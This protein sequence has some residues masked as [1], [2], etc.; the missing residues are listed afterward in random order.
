MTYIVTYHR[1]T[2]VN[3]EKRRNYCSLA[4]VSS[5]IQ[6]DPRYPNTRTM[7]LPILIRDMI[8]ANTPLATTPHRAQHPRSQHDDGNG[9]AVETANTFG[10]LGNHCAFWP[11]ASSADDGVSSPS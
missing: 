1:Q 4:K 10:R 5:T 7:T 6:I 3:L 9:I 2:S 8:D 11:V